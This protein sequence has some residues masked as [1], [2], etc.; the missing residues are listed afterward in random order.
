MCQNNQKLTYN[1]H[2]GPLF[3]KL[4]R[5][6][7]NDIIEHEPCEF[8][9]HYRE[10]IIPKPILALFPNNLT[11]GVMNVNVISDVNMF[12]KLSNQSHVI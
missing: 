5:L 8:A 9:F 7:L 1:S 11:D 4:K 10:N 6:K 3:K 12:P 2:R